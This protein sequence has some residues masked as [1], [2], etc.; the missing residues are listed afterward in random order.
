[1]R[2][3]GKA[4]GRKSW[5]D[6]FFPFRDPYGEIVV[7]TGNLP[8]PVSR[9]FAAKARTA[10]LCLD[11]VSFRVVH[12]HTTTRRFKTPCWPANRHEPTRK[13]RRFRRFILLLASM[14]R[15]RETSW[16]TQPPLNKPNVRT[17]DGLFRGLPR[18]YRFF[19]G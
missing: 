8:W 11:N 4:P 5:R 12:S 17:R 3:G 9:G 2:P 13:A 19:S 18:F 14:L 6:S 10:A 1:M 16:C 15:P 7:E